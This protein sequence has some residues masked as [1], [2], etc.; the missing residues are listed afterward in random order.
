MPSAAPAR[1]RLARRAAVSLAAGALFWG[2]PALAFTPCLVIGSPMPPPCIVI[3]GTKIAEHVNTIRNVSQ[4]IQEMSKVAENLADLKKIMQAGETNEAA[5]IS[6]VKAWVPIAPGVEVSFAI[7]ANEMSKLLPDSND[8]TQDE[9]DAHR[10][11]MIIGERAASGDG[12]S[13][14]QSI[15]ARLDGMRA[16]GELLTKAVAQ[17]STSLRRDWQLN[18]HARMLQLRSLVALREARQ[19]RT[20]YKAVVSIAESP[21]EEVKTYERG[22]SDPYTPEARPDFG[23]TITQ[24]AIRTAQLLA[25]KNGSDAA[26]LFAIALEQLTATRSEY[27]GLQQIARV[28]E[29]NLINL[30]EYEARRVGRDKNT[31]LS[32]L[33]QAMSQYDQTTWDDPG[34]NDAAKAAAVA[35]TK[36]AERQIGKDL[37]DDI[38]SA[39]VTRAEAFKQAA[40]FGEF[41]KDSNEYTAATSNAQAA[42]SEGLGVNIADRTALQNKIDVLTQEIEALKA[43]L[44]SAPA[45]VRQRAEAVTNDLKVASGAVSPDTVPDPG[46]T[47]GP[48][49]EPVDVR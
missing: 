26:A 5:S 45:D 25:L 11:A 41:A 27:E 2:S 37:S 19:N 22:D 33:N 4:Q 48:Q 10:A 44:S 46:E 40:F 36:A 28:T 35:A 20:V 34:K 6:N 13:I 21:I 30:V 15:K 1:R 12:W 49:A 18:T 29:Q 42:Y 9:T 8:L 31:I 38:V 43:E 24:I 16:D 17:C 7:A 39:L 32:I 3:D 23:K 14:A 47:D